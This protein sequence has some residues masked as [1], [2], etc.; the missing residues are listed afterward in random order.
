LEQAV[1]CGREILA[2]T[3]IPPE[4]RVVVVSDVGVL[5]R[6]RFGLTADRI[7]IDGA[8]QYARDALENSDLINSR[9]QYSSNL[10]AALSDRYDAF[11]DADDLAEAIDLLKAAVD[12]TDLADPGRPVRLL[13][14]ATALAR[15]FEV[16][17]ERGDIDL[18]ILDMTQVVQST[19]PDDP[20]LSL[21]LSNLSRMFLIRSSCGQDED[22]RRNDADLAVVRAQQALNVADSATRSSGRIEEQ[23][24]AALAHRYSITPNPSDIN[25]VISLLEDAIVADACPVAV[26][27]SRRLQLARALLQRHSLLQ[28]PSDLDRAEGEVMAVLDSPSASTEAR[29]LSGEFMAFIA[30]RRLEHPADPG[31]YAAALAAKRRASEILGHT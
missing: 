16:M 28:T 14:L 25:A 17:N 3:N 30:D 22:E 29:R 8:V 20:R 9:A 31:E 7:D 21:R 26:Q 23:A 10:G 6:D 2:D 27:L 24:A 19:Q 12:D 15:R 13:N 1:A 4:V 11:S 5:I 18:A